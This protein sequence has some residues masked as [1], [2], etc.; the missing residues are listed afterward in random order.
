MACLVSLLCIAGHSV[1]K[2]DITD[3]EEFL[4]KLF[5]GRGQEL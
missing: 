1:T 5:P 4:G 2:G 3:L